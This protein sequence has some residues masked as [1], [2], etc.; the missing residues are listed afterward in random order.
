MKI[1]KDTQ[2]KIYIKNIN[3]TC[4]GPGMVSCKTLCYNCQKEYF[5]VLGPELHLEVSSIYTTEFCNATWACLVHRGLSC[6]GRVY[7]TELCAVPG[8]VY[9]TGAWRCIWT[10]LDNTEPELL[11]E[12]SIPQGS[13]LHWNCLHYIGLCCTRTC[14]HIGAWAALELSTLQRPV[15]HLDEF[16]N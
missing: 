7:I 13:E 10:C 11:L 8:G 12:V 16:T 1:I 2:L 9:S 5:Y 6:T 14:L 15:L 4:L 3:T